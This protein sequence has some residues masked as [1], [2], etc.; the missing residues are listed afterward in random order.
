MNKI[1]NCEN[2]SVGYILVI[3]RV[4]VGCTIT[5]SSQPNGREENIFV[6]PTPTSVITYLHL[7]TKL[8]LDD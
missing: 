5:F 1:S 8:Q 3:T 6:H 7:K 4:G 2:L